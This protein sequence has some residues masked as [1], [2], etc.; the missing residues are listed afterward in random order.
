MRLGSVEMSLVILF[1]FWKVGRVGRD[2]N[3]NCSFVTGGNCSLS[4]RVDVFEGRY[5]TTEGSK[6]IQIPF[7]SHGY[8]SLKKRWPDVVKHLM[9]DFDWPVRNRRENS[10]LPLDLNF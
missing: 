9:I 6:Y 10:Q 3:N 5:C 4:L 7:R 8:S 2:K 1:Y